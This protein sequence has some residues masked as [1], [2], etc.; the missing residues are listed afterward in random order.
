MTDDEVQEAV[1]S[2]RWQLSSSQ[3]ESELPS[4]KP[5]TA[6]GQFISNTLDEEDPQRFI[7]GGAKPGHYRSFVDDIMKKLPEAKSEDETLTIVYDAFF[8]GFLP[9]IVR[10]GHQ[11]FVVVKHTLEDYKSARRIAGRLELY[12]GAAK[13]IWNYVSQ[14]KKD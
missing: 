9:A 4:Y 6:L 7:R 14:T 12:E 5:L 11:R 13:K 10:H 3:E 8:A 1:E 2:G